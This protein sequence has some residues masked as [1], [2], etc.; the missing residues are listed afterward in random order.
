MTDITQKRSFLLSIIVFISACSSTGSVDSSLS[1]EE[2]NKII[3]LSEPE[4]HQAN[5]EMTNDSTATLTL[6]KMY[7]PITGEQKFI[8]KTFINSH[9]KSFSL[10]QIS[11]PVDNDNYAVMGTMLTNARVIRDQ[12]NTSQI[13]SEIM[14]DPAAIKGQFVLT[15][16]EGSHHDK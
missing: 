11:V 16:L 14:I 1:P 4:S 13:L 8:I 12:L 9:Q 2:I 7:I 15:F 3:A 10:A 6:K 5:I